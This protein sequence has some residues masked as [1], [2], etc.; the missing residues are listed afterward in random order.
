MKKTLSLLGL[1]TLLATGMTTV[2]MAEGNDGGVGNQKTTET[3]IG[4]QLVAKP[5]TG[6]T[7]NTPSGQYTTTPPT[8]QTYTY[9][10]SGTTGLS[11]QSSGQPYP[12]VVGP[13]GSTQ[14]DATNPARSAPSGGDTNGGS[15]G[16]GNGS[17]R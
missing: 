7:V 11:A 9:P 4:G 14:P 10:K 5:A 8:A 1:A 16:S 17:S 6:N 2:T 12:G 15:G 3:Q 13:T